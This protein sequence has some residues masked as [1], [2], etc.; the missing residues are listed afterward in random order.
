M[1][2]LIDD[3]PEEGLDVEADSSAD[4]LKEV[5]SD[6]LKDS[7][8]KNDEVS[9]RFHL[10]RIKKT[11]NIDGQIELKYHPNCDRC[12]SDF[13]YEKNVDVHMVLA[14]LYENSRQ[15]VEDKGSEE[16]LAV[17]DLN[18]SYYN[19]D[20]FDLSELLREQIILSKPMKYI[21]SDECKGLCQHCGKNF[22]EGDCDCKEDEIDP[23]LAPL[24]KIKEVVK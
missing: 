18:F 12:L 6:T 14:P 20:R 22:N 5:I 23:R 21:C 19:G 9:L 4:W 8:R 10:L 7:F 17:D 24:A 13:E 11:I 15:R 16:E 1:V 3:I 2:I